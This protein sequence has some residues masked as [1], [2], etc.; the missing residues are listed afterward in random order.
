MTVWLTAIDHVQIA[1]P[2]GEEA[3]ARLFYAGVLGLRE[4][5]KPPNLAKR[6]GVW[7][8]GTGF[9]VHLGVE[10]DFR[11]AKKAH[12]CFRVN[13]LDGFEQALAAASIPVTWD[14]ELPGVRRFYAQDPFGNRLEF[15]QD[16]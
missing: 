9:Q 12:P 4:V 13:D 6:G 14:T 8:E 11:A 5:T 2:A 3:A 7:F 15:Q 10:A 16:R 1:M